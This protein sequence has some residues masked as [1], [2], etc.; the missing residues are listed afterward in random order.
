MNVT[1]TMACEF[2]SETND[3]FLSRT[4]FGIDQWMDSVDPGQCY[5]EVTMD[6]QNIGVSYDH[7][8]YTFSY[9]DD[10]IPYVITHFHPSVGNTHYHQQHCKYSVGSEPIHK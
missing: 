4:C 3:V 2:G 7:F 10:D 9:S 5:S 8:Q 6:I 1:V